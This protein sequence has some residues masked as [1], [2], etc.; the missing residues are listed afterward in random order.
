[1]I[2]GSAGIENHRQENSDDRSNAT[3]GIVC[4]FSLM[5]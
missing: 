1:M 4:D 3:R 5:Q 2:I